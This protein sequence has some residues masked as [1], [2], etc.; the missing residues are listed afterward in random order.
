MLHCNTQK[1][2]QSSYA[3][4]NFKIFAQLTVSIVIPF[5]PS[6]CTVAI[7]EPAPRHSQS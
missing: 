4:P 5:F 3:F 2:R 6:D 1:Q 7:T